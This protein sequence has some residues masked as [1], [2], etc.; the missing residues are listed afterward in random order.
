MDKM[1]ILFL[2]RGEERKNIILLK[3][4]GWATA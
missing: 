3:D 1:R 4:W 2:K